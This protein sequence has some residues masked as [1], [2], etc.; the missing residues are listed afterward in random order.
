[1]EEDLKMNKFRD[2]EFVDYFVWMWFGNVILVKK[3]FGI[4][5]KILWK[6]IVGL[7]FWGK[8]FLF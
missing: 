2:K 3:F 5:K 8:D 4:R 6:M 1:M 7:I